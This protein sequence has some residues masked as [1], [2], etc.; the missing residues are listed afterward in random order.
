MLGGI[1]TLVFLTAAFSIGFRLYLGRELL[2][3]DQMLPQQNSGSEEACYY[4]SVTVPEDKVPEDRASL[5]TELRRLSSETDHLLSGRSSIPEKYRRQR[6]AELWNSEL[7]RIS[8]SLEKRLPDS[9]RE[10]FLNSQ[11]IFFQDRSQQALKETE[12][13]DGTSGILLYLS[14]YTDLTGRRCQEILEKYY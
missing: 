5:E 13:E 7:S 12:K 11:K 2:L 10:E 4:T 6:A 9:E 3:Y 8:G 14:C 1:L